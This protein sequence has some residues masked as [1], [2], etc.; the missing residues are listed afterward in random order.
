MADGTH[1]WIAA[2]QSAQLADCPQL[3]V[4]LALTPEEGFAISSSTSS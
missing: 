3:T 4:D 2:I 1:L